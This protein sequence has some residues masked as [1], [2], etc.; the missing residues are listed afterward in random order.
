M[1]EAPSKFERDYGALKQA[2]EAKGFFTTPQPIKQPGDRLVVASERFAQGLR[3]VSFLIARRDTGWYVAAW[4]PRIYRIP[5]DC[6]VDAVA[7]EVLQS[8]GGTPYDFSESVKSK[9]GL[10]EVS[11][12]DF[13]CA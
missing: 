5:E 9:Y 11:D 12:A 7:V 6:L 8:G 3:G 4:L 2:V 10:V 13:D 1:S